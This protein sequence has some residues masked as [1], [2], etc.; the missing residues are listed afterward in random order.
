MSSDDMVQKYMVEKGLCE[1]C[2]LQS[3][4][5]LDASFDKYSFYD[6][7][8]E[9]CREKYGVLRSFLDFLKREMDNKIGYMEERAEKEFV[10]GYRAGYL[11]GADELREFLDGGEKNE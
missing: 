2:K 6:S 7:F 10:D 8:C 4:E 1:G 9:E 3:E 11:S 5:S